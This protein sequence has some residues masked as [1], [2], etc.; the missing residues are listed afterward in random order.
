MQ[1]IANGQQAATVA[2]PWPEIAWRSIG[3]FAQIIT[4]H[5]MTSPAVRLTADAPWPQWIIVK[6]NIPPGSKSGY[7]PLVANYRSQF[8]KLWPRRG[9]K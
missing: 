9:G 8:L 2:F 1:Y 7:F 6:A 4:G 5:A 3:V